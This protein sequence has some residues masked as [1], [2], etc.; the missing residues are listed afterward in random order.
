MSKQVNKTE[1]VVLTH[2]A[3]GTFQNPST[4]KWYVTE[5]SVN[6]LTGQAKLT[7]LY[8]AGDKD[9]C[10]ELFKLKVID[11]DLI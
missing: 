3:L 9:S 10:N 2:K 8:E 5:V 7:N 4:K 11:L 6:P 1:E